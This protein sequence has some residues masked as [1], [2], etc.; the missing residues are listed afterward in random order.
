M[1]ESEQKSK[2]W[3][4]YNPDNDKND[5]SSKNSTQSFVLLQVQTC[6]KAFTQK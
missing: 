4:Q 6:H 2:G 1:E 5:F 3:T